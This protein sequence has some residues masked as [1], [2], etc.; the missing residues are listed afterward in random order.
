MLLIKKFTNRKIGRQG[1]I[2]ILKSPGDTA[3]YKSQLEAGKPPRCCSNNREQKHVT[4][5]PP[6]LKP[7][8]YCA[9]GEK[10]LGCNNYL[11]RLRIVKVESECELGSSY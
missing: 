8:L 3:S 9:T 2:R 6:P 4:T 10:R 7:V 1:Q 11:A 5:I